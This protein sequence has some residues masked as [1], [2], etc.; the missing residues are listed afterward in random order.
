MRRKE[1]GI[2]AYPPRMFEEISAWVTAQYATWVATKARRV[3]RVLKEGLKEKKEEKKEAE[4]RLAEAKKSGDPKAVQR[5]KRDLDYAKEVI[6]ATLNDIKGSEKILAL[7]KKDGAKGR[8]AKKRKKQFPLDLTG[9]PKNYPID[10][11]S[12]GFSKITVTVEFTGVLSSSKSIG[13]SWND[14]TRHL[15]VLLHGTPPQ[16]RYTYIFY[17]RKM[18]TTLKH[19]LRHMVQHL[20]FIFEAGLMEKKFVE[21]GI[22]WEDLSPKEQERIR[23]SIVRGLPKEHDPGTHKRLQKEVAKA[24]GNVAYFL[25]PREFFTWIGNAERDFLQTVRENRKEFFRQRDPD[26]DPKPTREE[27]DRFVGNPRPVK[28]RRGP[29]RYVGDPIGTH[30]FFEALWEY[31]KPRWR[32]AVKEVWKR[33]QNKVVMPQA[34]LPK[35]SRV[36]SLYLAKRFTPESWAK[37]KKKHPGAEAKHHE[38]VKPEKGKEDGK[39]GKLKPAKSVREKLDRVLQSVKGVSKSVAKSI[40]NAPKNVQKF[41]VD[42][43]YRDKVTKAA[44]KAAKE[45]PGKIKQAVLDS[46]KSELKAIFKETPKILASLV[47]EQRAPTRAEAKTLYGVG[48][49]VAGTVLAMSGAGGAGVLLAG[50]R[51]FGHSLGLHIG[52]KAINRLADE[53]FLAY[54]A[55]ESAAQAGGMADAL[56]LNT[57]D[58]PGLNQIWDAVSTVVTGAEKKSEPTMERMVERLIEIVTDELE[59]G[60]SDEDIAEILKE[61]QP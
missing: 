41:V 40:R 46:G 20:F 55:V 24:P 12:K 25:E 5:A 27:F 59:K 19:E 9:M 8:G 48:V 29:L 33:V 34:K 35:A 21:R 58:L 23:Q 49:Y 37:Y 38:I 53:G 18:E 42:K 16:N 17:I 39:G 54:E 36:A 3:I 11:L 13:G 44:A 1:G 45:A 50:A 30:P 14:N 26:Y 6:Q 22:K 2:I 60:L 7:A 28:A 4:A 51:A 43:D 47:K 10:L 61:E 52:I 31:D 57:G 56:P 15:R 32:R